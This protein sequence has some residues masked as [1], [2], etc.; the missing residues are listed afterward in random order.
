MNFNVSSAFGVIGLCLNI[1]LEKK[2][3]RDGNHKSLSRLIVVNEFKRILKVAWLSLI[4]FIFVFPL[5]VLLA[6]NFLIN[7]NQIFSEFNHASIT[8]WGATWSFM[9]LAT[10]LYL[11][12]NNNKCSLLVKTI[13]ILQRKHKSKCLVSE[14]WLLLTSV[15][16]ISLPLFQFR[17]VET[18]LIASC[19]FHNLTESFICLL[20]FV[21][22][23]GLCRIIRRYCDK[24]KNATEARASPMLTAPLTV[25]GR[26]FRNFHAKSLCELYHELEETLLQI[27][28]V[29][30]CLMNL[31]SL[32][33]TLILMNCLVSFT[34]GLYQVI[35]RLL[36][37]E[38]IPP[39]LLL[40]FVLQ[41]LYVLMLTSPPDAINDAVS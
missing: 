22:S 14:K 30:Y 7:L 4:L 10:Y 39:D 6:V 18:L 34:M 24:L 41:L 27:D 31:L 5:P 11:L 1:T 8:L 12:F 16:G 26:Q 28:D 37:G 29:R 25:K 13:K 32:P 33:I 38:V 3:E 23:T 15:I 9:K 2:F 40:Q 21:Y 19:C 17:T 35:N 36:N 20:F